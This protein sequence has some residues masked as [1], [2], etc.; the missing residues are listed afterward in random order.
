MWLHQ[1]SHSLPLPA[2]PFHSVRILGKTRSKGIFFFLIYFLI[3]KKYMVCMS[4]E[5]LKN[6]STEVNSS[7][8]YVTDLRIILLSYHLVLA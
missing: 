3:G 4:Q 2:I 6:A 5:N 8:R 1:V 7:F